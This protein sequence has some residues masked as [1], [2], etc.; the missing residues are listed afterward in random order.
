MKLHVVLV[1]PEIPQNTGNIGRTCAATGAV[2]HLV[3]PLGFSIEDKYLKRAGLD[4]WQFLDVRYYDNLDSF[5]AINHGGDFI[6]TSTK[7]YLNHCELQYSDNV[8]LIFGKET[9]GLPEGLLK[10]NLNRCVRIPMK[11]EARSLNLATAAAIMVYEVLRQHN[12]ENMALTGK[13]ELINQGRK[14]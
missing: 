14:L 2:L 4:Y 9:R 1:E 6:Y 3:K 5:F 11:Q 8:F 12:F 13:T 10:K 7:A